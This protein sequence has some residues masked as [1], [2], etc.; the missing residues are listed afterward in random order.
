[1]TR[2]TPRG[3]D[4]KRRHQPTPV[5][6]PNSHGNHQQRQASRYVPPISPASTPLFAWK[7]TTTTMIP[8]PPAI[9]TPP[10]PQTHP[11]PAAILSGP[12]GL[13]P[14]HTPAISH[15]IDPIE[16]AQPSPAQPSRAGAQAWVWVRLSARVCKYA[17]RCTWHFGFLCRQ[18]VA[19]IV[20]IREGRKA[21]TGGEG[22]SCTTKTA[23]KDLCW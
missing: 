6:P 8:P 1:M 9:P 7:K 18:K 17:G 5:P 10:P 15:A 12:R 20:E 22:G 4:R 13:S 23:M 16:R 21:S 2:L 3:H 19:W 14:G 11:Q